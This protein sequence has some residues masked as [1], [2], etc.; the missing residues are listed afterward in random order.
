M[1]AYN[2]RIAFLAS[3]MQFID[4]IDPFQGIAVEKHQKMAMSPFHFFRGSAQIFYGDLAAG[5]LT[6]PTDLIQTVPMVRIQ[7]DCHFSNFGFLT[8]ETAVG[9][10]VIWCP[11]DYDDAAVGHAAWDLIRFATSLFLAADYAAGLVSGLYQSEQGPYG[12]TFQGLTYQDV[13]KAV[14]AFLKAYQKACVRIADN[15]AERDKA[16]AGF[17]KNHALYEGEQK[18]LAR[19]AGGKKFKT[20]SALMKMAEIYRAK[21]RF[22][23]ETDKLEYLDPALYGEISRVF[24]PYVDDDIQDI[25]RRV[26]AGTGSVNMDR[27][28]L[29]VGPGAHNE[30]ELHRNYIIEVKR[31][32]EAALIRHFPDLSPVNQ[33]NPA[34]LTIDCQR[35]MQRKPDVVLDEVIWRDQHWL[36]RSRHHARYGYDPEQLVRD[37]PG[38]FLKSYA[39]ACGKALARAHARSDRKSQDFEIA[40]AAVLEAKNLRSE[41]LEISESYFDQVVSDWAAISSVIKM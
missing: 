1:T 40:M 31:Q 14:L 18:A 2:R 3:E 29:L 21:L 17:R 6:A 19:S 30:A 11:N 34:H 23:L 12:P 16:V 35:L 26:G 38:A 13:K 33:L 27:F 15:V 37:H 5:V 39:K 25:A 20:K 41:I 32:R 36:V 7:G 28:Y 10:Q 8:E 4:G 24:R 22:K 9:D